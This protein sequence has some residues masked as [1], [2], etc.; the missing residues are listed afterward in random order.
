M[1]L[2]ASNYPTTRPTLNLDFAKSKQLDPRITFTRS[3]SGTYVDANGIIQ[4]AATDTARFDH[5]PATGESLGLLVEEA[6]TNQITYSNIGFQNEASVQ[7][8]AGLAP[9]NTW[10]AALVTG[11]NSF[12]GNYSTPGAGTFTYSIFVKQGTSPTFRL[13]YS[14]YGY[15][16]WL[17]T[18]STETL[19]LSTGWSDAKVEKYPN[20]WYRLSATSASRALYYY[21]FYAS[22]AT[23]TVYFWG[24]HREAA[25][26]P[27]SYIP[28]PATFTSRASSAT[29]YDSSGVI[30]TAG[31]NVAR[32]AAYFPDS[33]GVMRSAGL[34]L[35]AAATN[36]VTYSE[37]FDNAAWIKNN[38]SVTA[39]N[40]SAPDGNV[41]ADKFVE[42]A[43]SAYH[44]VQQS[45]ISF[46]ASTSYTLSVFA[47]AS[48]RSRIGFGGSSLMDAQLGT[49]QGVVFDLTGNGS[50]V[51]GGSG[52][53]ITKL[54]N[55][56]YKCS[57]TWSQL[58]TGSYYVAFGPVIT[59][60]TNYTG[61]GTSGIFAWGAQ[62]EA[63][64][65][66]TSYIATTTATV[67]RS[68]DVSSSAT[69][70]RSADVAKISGTN[71]QSFI[72]Y[73]Q[74]TWF[75]QV[76]SLGTSTGGRLFDSRPAI[77][78]AAIGPTYYSYASSGSS[79]ITTA[80][81]QKAA[82]VYSQSD[83]HAAANGTL[84]TGNTG[85]RSVSHSYIDIGSANTAAAGV[86]FINAPI[87][88][89]AYW[90]TRLSDATLQAI[91]A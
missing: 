20:G 33:N 19:A 43:T 53:T 67:T 91:T 52:A 68:A 44:T 89:L 32:S 59:N 6:R 73:E 38:L 37:Q 60:T 40:T 70:T 26:F 65:Y 22:S 42:S 12:W 88:R 87:S 66:P 4:S 51:V 16:D 86:G 30:Q 56:W 77:L 76:S 48:E 21:G 36:L 55:G 74:G 23:T 31:T 45:S 57:Y 14:G 71:Y 46:T 11:D 85:G 39:N 75:S 83:V 72:N 15:T 90:P 8:F 78:Y 80:F 49:A 13:I 28:T 25:S 29:Y 27:T 41:T 61:D 69:V 3:S 62:L 82:V 5:N 9:D 47:K 7:R 63:S 17:F 35:E 81:P 18:F 2:K 34:L 1:T 64:S 50:V 10:T 79:N 58:N 54:G 24:H 84:N